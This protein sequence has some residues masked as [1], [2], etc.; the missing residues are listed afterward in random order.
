MRF[1]PT[2]ITL[3]TLLTSAVSV[4]AHSIALDSQFAAPLPPPPR[5][6]P[7]PPPPKEC[8]KKLQQKAW[9]TLTNKQKKDY[10]NADLCLMGK[11]A[12]LGLPATTNRFKELQSIY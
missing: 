7:P 1:S 4:S 8:T 12:T 3:V 11:P 5:P 10:I 6:P 2:A 9:H